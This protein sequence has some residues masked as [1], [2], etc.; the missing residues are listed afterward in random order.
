MTKRCY[1]C[2][3]GKLKIIRTELRP[4]RGGTRKVFECGN[5]GLVFLDEKKENLRELYGSKEYRKKAG[6]VIGKPATSQQIFDTYYPVMSGR[7]AKV[8]KYL[9]KNKRVLDIG[10]SAGHFLA[11]VKPFVKEAVGIELSRDNAAFVRKKLGLKV[12]TTPIEETDLPK[13]HFDVIFCLQTFEHI[14]DPA[15]FLESLRPYLKKGG[16]VYVEVPNRDEGTL[17]LYHNKAYD[18]FYYHDAHLFYY[19]PKTLA[20]MFKKAG[21]VGEVLPFQWYNFVNQMHWLLANGPQRSG[22]DGLKDPE[23][24]TDSNVPKKVRDEFNAFIRRA[25]RDYK[26]LL[27]KHLRSDQI[28]FVGKSKV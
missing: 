21:Y 8:K 25:D 9:G 18:D 12:Y 16:V 27:E 24:V 5:C 2:G 3:S 13:G 7:L 10:C 26:N 22:F 6:P 28:V 14:P 20:R 1:L 19:N 17:S 4:G 23:L 15:H 11:T